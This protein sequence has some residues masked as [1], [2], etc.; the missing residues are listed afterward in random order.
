MKLLQ[1]KQFKK[2]GLFVGFS[3]VALGVGGGAFYYQKS[4]KASGEGAD[5]TPQSRSRLLIHHGQ[6][7]IDDVTSGTNEIMNVKGKN[8]QGVSMRN[9][10]L[11]EREFAYADARGGNFQGSVF[12]SEKLNSTNFEGAKMQGVYIL[13]RNT[14]GQFDGI[15]N[16]TNFKKARM[17]RGNFESV[18]FAGA[19]FSGASLKRA[20]LDKARFVQ[21]TGEVSG[22][23]NLSITNTSIRGA[24]LQGA[25]IT[26][27]QFS[28]VNGKGANFQ[29]AK[30]NKTEIYGGD[31][32]G[33]DFRDVYP[34]PSFKGNVLI[35]EMTQFSRDMTGFI[36]IED[37]ARYLN[38]RPPM[39]VTD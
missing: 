22:A 36:T 18:I 17:Q 33:A 13:N 7:L 11:K 27:A 8:F 14:R 1:F 2:V 20:I 32:R 6:D 39:F 37:G 35:D 21:H 28:M 26:E 31:F 29:G 9:M 12:G 38:Y 24:K 16:L 5:R 34:L 3:V 23:P 15:C 4:M 30:M 19:D 25:R 10:D